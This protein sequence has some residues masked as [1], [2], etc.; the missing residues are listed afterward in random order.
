LLK[1][2]AKK[3]VGLFQSSHRGCGHAIQ[4]SFV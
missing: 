1:S 2:L 4:F 3:M